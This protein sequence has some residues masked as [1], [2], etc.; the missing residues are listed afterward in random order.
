[1]KKTLFLKRGLFASF[2]LVL[3]SLFAYQHAQAQNLITNGDFESGNG[4]GFTSNYT[5]IT[6]GSS[7]QK[8]YSIVTNPQT[9]NAAFNACTDHTSGSGKM[10][11][12]DGAFSNQD[13]I[14]EQSP[15]GGISVVQ[16]KKYTFTYWIQTIGTGGNLADIEVKINNVT[17]TPKTGSTLAPSA[18]CSWAKVTYEWT[19][20]SGSAQIWLYDKTTVAGGNDFAIDDLSLIGEPDPLT[21][22]YAV[23]NPSCPDATD[24]YITVYA[25]GGTAPYQYSLNGGA[26]QSNSIFSGLAPSINNFV[27]VKDAT[28]PTPN[29]VSS[30]AVINVVAP[31]NDLIVRNDTTICKGSPVKL[32]VSGGNASDYTWVASPADATLTSPASSSPTVSPAVTTTYTVTSNITT[33]QNLIYN[34]GFELGNIGFISDYTF[35]STLPTRARRSYGITKSPFD[36]DNFFAVTTDHSGTGYMMVV[37]GSEV[38]GGNDRVWTQTIPVKQ[39][40]TY[41]FKYW[42]QT[43]A[44]PSPARLETQINGSPITGNASTSTYTCSAAIDG[45]RQV[46]Y[47]W[48]S[49]S[50]NTATL[51]IYNRNTAGVGNDMALDD[52]EFYTSSSCSL[53]KTVTVTVDQPAAKPNVTSPVNYCINTEATALSA[54][55]QNLK[56]YTTINGV[57]ST[58]APIP[59]TTTVGQTT[60]YVTQTA[61]NACGES[62]KESIVVNVIDKTPKPLVTSPLN[63]CINSQAVA[64]TANGTGLKWYTT[65]NGTGNTTAPVPSTSSVGQTTYYVT[66][67]L[68]NTCG[69][70]DKESIVVNIIDKP[71]KPSVSGPLNY[72]INSQAVA[73]T[74]SG[75][76]LLWYT[77]INGQGSSTAP[78]PSTTT[79]GQTTYYVTQNLENVC[80]ESD[81]QSIVVN[82][83]DKTAKPVVTSPVS[84]CQNTTATA[85]TATGTS[86]LW[87]TSLNGQGSSTAPT[88]LTSS[89]G[90]TTY[91]VSQNLGTVCGESDKESIV[92]NVTSSTSKP[93]VSSPVTYCQNSTATQLTATGSNLLWYTSLT[94]QGSSTAPTPSTNSAGTTTYYVSQNTGSCGESQREQIDVVVYATPTVNAGQDAEITIGGSATLTGQTNTIGSYLWT[95]SNLVDK[96]TELITS[97]TPA[98]TTTFK[99]TVTDNETNCK[100][101]DEVTISIKPASPCTT[102]MPPNAF[103]PN[104]DGFYDLWNIGRPECVLKMQVDVYN[105]W[106]GQVY[107]ADD[108]KNDWDGRYK[109]KPLPDA[110]YYYVIR[111]YY[112]DN[113]N[114]VLRGNVTILR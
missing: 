91:Y 29:E 47:T 82:V 100:A 43:V 9:F 54:T 73:L 33:T 112:R 19:A 109:G 77:S 45:W 94:G 38:N 37:D 11:V 28:S 76:N 4:I 17:Q 71:A 1:M 26:Y 83:V 99:L 62:E 87:Y 14:W 113:S 95:P 70:S 8:N 85:L 24:G 78:V 32:S 20:T 114:R 5:Y 18:V 35:Y 50:S 111:V 93:I 58:T 23:I 13:K 10:M 57:G 106:G 65:L 72:C 81:K 98:N 25:K 88:P 21:I 51:T 90:Q 79:A 60:Y 44:T 101:S 2:G 80:G 89:V 69:E 63:L 104:N 56:W 102:L 107:H 105:I 3:L 7:A 39:N 96:P 110:T 59:V 15:G 108:Y 22:S 49:G 40:T 86:L 46:T 64:L 53:S 41:N 92:V 6:S 36:F 16:G 61:E 75:S 30:A 12:V 67:D 97:A 55:G 52:M 68:G 103:T 34:P 84:Y 66:Q 27:S 48:N 42:V 31:V 74:A